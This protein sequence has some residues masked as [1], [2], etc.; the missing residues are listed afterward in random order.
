MLIGKDFFKI[1]RCRGVI[2]GGVLSSTDTIKTNKPKKRSVVRW[3]CSR[4][5]C[6]GVTGAMG[7]EWG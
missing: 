2:Q 5:K 1:K 7:W 6:A 3:Y 4:G